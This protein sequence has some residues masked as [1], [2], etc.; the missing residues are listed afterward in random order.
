MTKGGTVK[1]HREYDFIKRGRNVMMKMAL[2]DVMDFMDEKNIH[3][4]DCIVS[5]NFTETGKNAAEQREQDKIYNHLIDISDAD[6]VRR[7]FPDNEEVK[8]LHLTEGEEALLP[9]FC[10]L[11]NDKDIAR[12]TKNLAVENIHKFR[13][14]I[15]HKFM[16]TDKTGL[17]QKAKDLGMIE[18][19]CPVC[20][21]RKLKKKK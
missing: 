13:T 16:V 3:D 4:E 21:K 5:L 17:L 11:M 12:M 7:N 10:A 9:Y 15:Y 14:G 18:E 8:A 2:N 6:K 20:A 1:F 19:P